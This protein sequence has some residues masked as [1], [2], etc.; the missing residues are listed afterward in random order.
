MN[1]PGNDPGGNGIS[2]KETLRSWKAIA[3]YLG[4]ST[5]TARRWETEEGLPVHRHMHQSRGS[6]Y[7]YRSEIDA[8]RRRG[9]TRATAAGTVTGPSAPAD[10]PAIAVLPFAYVGPDAASDYLADGFTEEV[11]ADLSKIRGL[12]VISRTSSMALKHTVKDARQIGR[13]LAAGHLL[14]GT[15]RRHGDRIRVSV[16]L[17]DPT[18]DH[19]LWGGKYDGVL[20]EVFA[21]QEQ[22]AR[23]IAGAMKLHLS[24]GDERRLSRHPLDDVSAW[25]LAVQARQESLRWRRE[26]IDRAV[27]LLETAIASAG[28]QAALQAALGRTWLQYREAGIDLGKRPVR[29]A[30]A[31][32]RAI[33]AV[34]PGSAAGLQLRGWIHYARG[35]IQDAVRDLS[36]A[37][38]QDWNDPDVLGLLANCY[39]ISGRVSLARPLI[40]RLLAVDPLTPLN[41]CLPGWA[42]ALEGRFEAAVGAYQ[43]MLDMDPGNPVARLFYVWILVSAGRHEEARVACKAFPDTARGTPAARLA[44]LLAADGDSPPVAAADLPEAGDASDVFPRLLA[45]ACAIAGDHDT[46]LHWLGVAVERGFINFPYLAEHDPLLAP[47]R[48]H[49]GFRR[50]MEQ[51]RT[52]WEGFEAWPGKD[53]SLPTPAAGPI[54]D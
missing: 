49:A 44:A 2:G 16:R 45:Q 21:I 14:E 39:L 9:E 27:G 31:C 53:R 30:E 47:L 25:Q 50:L 5:R 26:S 28:D 3:G 7:A 8:W 23:Q 38:L 10:T 33:L 15:V 13:E 18:R 36:A 43:D 54:I 37:L 42:D 34:D 11:I 46:A 6:V 29:E 1:T 4:C 51:V 22:I 41:R 48:G 20:D 32:A 19:P 40:E 35:N 52:R 17:I 12:R 24:V